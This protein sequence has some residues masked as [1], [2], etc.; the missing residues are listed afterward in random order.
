MIVSL[1]AFF[2]AVICLI[3]LEDPERGN[4][5]SAM[6]CL[7]QNHNEIIES[8]EDA[9]SN[10][11]YANQPP[12]QESKL[13]IVGE[14]NQPKSLVESVKCEQK[15]NSDV[16]CNKW[17]YRT[18]KPS[19][20][21]TLLLMKTPTIILILIQGIPSVIPLGIASTFLNDYLSQEKG[22]TVEVRLSTFLSFAKS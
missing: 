2:T 4:K 3:F 21:S 9:T 7:V 8:S 17:L 6:I 5:E 16:K 15:E 12:I 22:L 20:R 10:S 11:I 19:I 14:A 1:P 18:E 13:K